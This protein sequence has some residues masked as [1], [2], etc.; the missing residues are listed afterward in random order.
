[1]A[2]N[3]Q[4]TGEHEKWDRASGTGGEEGDAIVEAS[5]ILRGQMGAYERGKEVLKYKYN[6]RCSDNHHAACHPR[7]EH[8]RGKRNYVE[9]KPP[10]V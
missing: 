1:M 5:S 7:R 2:T 3:I 9:E 10:S 8:Q 4:N 6:A